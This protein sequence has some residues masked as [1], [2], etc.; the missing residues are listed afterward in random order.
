[1]SAWRIVETAPDGKRI[2]KHDN[3]DD[4]EDAAGS[5]LAYL[6]DMRKDENVLVVV[7]RWYGG[8]HLGP[9]RFAHIV[10]V[11]RELLVSN[12]QVA[13]GVSHNNMAGRTDSNKTSKAAFTLSSKQIEEYLDNGLLVVENVLSHEE[14]ERAKSGFQQSLQARGVHSF[15]EEDEASAR[16]FDRLSS[17]NGSGGV[18]DIHY[19]DW[20]LQGVATHPKLYSVTTQLWKAAY[21]RGGCDNKDSLP[22]EQQCQWHPFGNDVD[23]DKGYVYIDRAWGDRIHP[24]QKRKKLRAV[25][26]SLTPHLDCCPDDFFS[27]TSQKWRPIQ[28]FV[29]LTDNLDANTGGFEAAPGFHRVFD[30]WAKE[31]RQQMQT[32]NNDNSQAPTSL[33]V[34]EY[35]HIRPKEDAEVMKQ[36]KHIPVTAGSAVFWDNRLPHA[37]SY[38][39]DSHLPRMVV[40]CSFLPDIEKNRRYVRHQLEAWKQGRSVLDQW[41]NIDESA[42]HEQPNRNHLESRD[43]TKFTLLGKRLMG[44]ESW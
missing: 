31:R 5:K 35:T 42:Q 33:C 1:M 26:R 44:I 36:V 37:N 9:K 39:N 25:Q 34:G 10:N 16:A 7:S 13:A 38:R 22:L 18:L 23:F 8:V 14:I 12:P 28:C 40:Y 19:D 32:P 11:A 43:E 6:L 30:H 15:E 29:S 17:T 20:K 3:D 2:I 24:E 41:N 21:N 27:D 4:G